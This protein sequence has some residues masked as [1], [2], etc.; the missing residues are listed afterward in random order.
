[1]ILKD[2]ASGNARDYEA[3]LESSCALSRDLIRD[4]NIVHALITLRLHLYALLL[5]FLHLRLLL[6]IAL[7]ILWL[8]VTVDSL[9]LVATNLGL[10]NLDLLVI[11]DD[12][13]V[14]KS[15]TLL[16]PGS[17]LKTAAQR[18]LCGGFRRGGIG[19]DFAVR[20]RIG[21]VVLGHVGFSVGLE[22]LDNVGAGF[23]G[24]TGRNVDDGPVD[25]LDVCLDQRR[26][27]LRLRC[28]V[29]LRA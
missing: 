22:L 8:A 10:L 14:V 16:G 27:E 24:A 1:M 19:L 21:R 11:I 29:S 4:K 15:E 3:V 26:E 25:G 9:S 20:G 13:A 23:D 6:H 12:E 7:L 28:G 17:A 18:S 5:A 2:E